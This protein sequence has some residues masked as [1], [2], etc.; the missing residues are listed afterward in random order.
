[1]PRSSLAHS[2]SSEANTA[3]ATL[4]RSALSRQAIYD[5]DL[6]VWAYELKYADPD[7]TRPVVDGSDDTTSSLI[8]SAFSEF[9]VERVVGQKKAFIGASYSTLTGEMPLPIPSARVALQI[10]DYQHPADELVDCVARR[11]DEGFAIVLEDFVYSAHSDALLNLVD[12]V[13]LDFARLRA[14]GLR[15]HMAE[16]RRFAVR[17]IAAGL[18]NS[19]QVRICEALGIDCFQGDFL[20]KP[21]LLSRR[22]LP[23]S[24]MILNDLLIRL[25]DPDVE[26]Q[27]IEELVKR[28]PGL[29]VAVLRFLNSSAYGFRQRVSSVSQ[30][31]ALLGLSEFTKWALL[32]SLSSRFDKPS[33]LLI[34][35]MVRA[36]TCE[37]YARSIRQKPDQ[38]FMVGLL[39]ILDA[40]LDR[41]MNEVLVE[42]PLSDEVRAAILEL[43]GPC[44]DILDRVLSRERGTL[45]LDEAD[46]QRLGSAW[47]EAIEWAE[48]ARGSGLIG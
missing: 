32:V 14:D 39:S 31:V 41:P 35:A 33:E 13:K 9:G 12:Y 7:A 40:L 3:G 48:S 22:E 42:L 37:N 28:D 1:M 20:F 8:L 43:S 21:Q 11:K 34:T 19:A 30:A 44:G 4:I 6:S 16:L 25:Q 38:A 15:E 45:V 26:F 27:E 47:I 29:S 17:P 36:R 23:S 24:F 46:E 2:F 5:R 18:A 10:R